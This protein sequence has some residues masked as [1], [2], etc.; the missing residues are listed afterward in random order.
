M[1]T[2]DTPRFPN[3]AKTKEGA[4][5]KKLKKNVRGP[6]FFEMYAG[7]S[8]KIKRQNFQFY[9]NILFLHDFQ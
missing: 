7:F 4:K 6:S 2:T 1:I 8:F 5:N 9:H 3:I